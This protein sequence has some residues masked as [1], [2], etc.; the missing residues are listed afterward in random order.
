MKRNDTRRGICFVAQFPPPM[1]GLSKAVDTLYRSRLSERYALKRIDIKNNLTFPIT[2]LRILF[3]RTDLFY[4]TISQSRGG[5]LRDLILLWFMRLRRL[6]CVVHL[7]GGC[8]RKMVEQLPPFWKKCN[9]RAIGRLAA[10]VVLSPSL[11]SNFAGLLPNERIHVV[12]NCVDDVFLPAEDAVAQKIARFAER[13][14]HRVLYLSNFIR[15]KGYREV[16][17]LARMEKQR[18]DAGGTRR[19]HFDLAGAFFDPTE[20]AFFDDYIQKNELSP[21]VTYHGVVLGAQKRALLEAADYF[22]LL[23]R[24][25]NEGQPISIL[26]AMGNGAFILSTDHAAIPDILP[27]GAGA[28]L[29]S[30]DAV[31]SGIAELYRA[32]LSLDPTEGMQK[33]A[34][35]AHAHYT[36]A[37]YVGDME[38]LFCGILQKGR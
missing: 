6:P 5:N 30:A 34:A 19:F 9:E 33:N 4:F 29:L 15:E 28:I 23:T 22:A 3:C 36:A 38:D 18:T 32:L 11:R 12:P 24:Y 8:Y 13:K 21:Y 26:E 27:K 25:P 10:A 7:H 1:H 14:V 20:R 31:E 35:L 17:A 37:R 16:L 2:L